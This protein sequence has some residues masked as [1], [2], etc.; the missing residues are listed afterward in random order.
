MLESL[1]N[2]NPNSVQGDR[3]E[4]KVKSGKVKQIENPIDA[5]SV[6]VGFGSKNLAFT[7]HNSIYAYG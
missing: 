6:A 7:I 3:H 5:A 1:H 4:T 2:R